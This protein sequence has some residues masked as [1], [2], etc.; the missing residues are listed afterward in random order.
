MVFFIIFIDKIKWS[1]VFEKSTVEKNQKIKVAVEFIMSVLV[2]SKSFLRFRQ[3]FDDIALLTDHS[4][5]SRLRRSDEEQIESVHDRVVLKKRKF[6]K[7][8]RNYRF[9]R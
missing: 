4:S 3:G 6:R 1:P 7:G 5:A 8:E 2:L 9:H